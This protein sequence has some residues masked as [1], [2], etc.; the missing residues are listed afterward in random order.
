MGMAVLEPLH[1]TCGCSGC[2]RSRRPGRSPLQQRMWA[3]ARTQHALRSRRV[4]RS[5]ARVQLGNRIVCLAG[6]G[7][8]GAARRLV[9]P[10]PY[11]V[12]AIS[13]CTAGAAAVIMA[14][15]PAIERYE[16][17]LICRWR[18]LGERAFAGTVGPCPQQETNVDAVPATRADAKGRTPSC[19]IL[20]VEDY[21]LRVFAAHAK[22]PELAVVQ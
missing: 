15:T 20:S 8:H 13:W 11:I 2:I 16:S 17:C 22:N 14:V 12:R 3:A 9:R 1:Q 4:V 7:G 21:G 6:C 5:R 18:T 19:S 10:T